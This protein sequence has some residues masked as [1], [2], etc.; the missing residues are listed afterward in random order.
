MADVTPADPPPEY[1]PPTG[2]GPTAVIDDMIEV[3]FRLSAW[4][5]D[6]SKRADLHAYTKAC[7]EYLRGRGRTDADLW[8]ERFATRL[9]NHSIALDQ[10]YH[11]RTRTDIPIEWIQGVEMA[12]EIVRC[13]DI[14]L[15][16]CV[17]GVWRN[18]DRAGD[19]P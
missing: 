4:G 18:H 1:P 11:D 5:L 12:A 16:S 3:L 7:E 13:N 14:G 15:H 19:Q 9:D 10:A 8:A 2:G 17:N 6:D